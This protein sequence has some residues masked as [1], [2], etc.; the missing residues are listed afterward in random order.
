MAR[1][2][3][4]RCSVLS[5]QGQPPCTSCKVACAACNAFHKAAV[6]AAGAKEDLCATV[7][8]S[9]WWAN[10]VELDLKGQ[11]LRRLQALDEL[12]HLRKAC[13]ADNELSVVQGL[14]ACTA[15]LELHLQVCSALL[16]HKIA[17][18]CM[19]HTQKHRMP[20]C[21]ASRE[22][23]Y[24]PCV[25]TILPQLTN[26][27]TE[28][29]DNRTKHALCAQKHVVCILKHLSC[30]L[31]REQGNYISQLEGLSQLPTLTLLDLSH[32][33]LSRLA[34]LSSLT[35]LQHLNI[36]SNQIVSLAG[37]YTVAHIKIRHSLL[38][39]PLTFCTAW[40]RSPMHVC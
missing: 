31:L 21:S 26:I 30:L 38:T 39:W 16:Q 17:C 35:Q 33:K 18:Y 10:V 9:S 12:T 32:N 1:S 13:L 27:V 19:L 3:F 6:D 36:C 25:L 23:E 40:Q 2:R 37:L 22:Y 29:T 20:C 5:I 15:L 14:A 24:S 8:D 28:D 4:N 34:P 11:G 7:H